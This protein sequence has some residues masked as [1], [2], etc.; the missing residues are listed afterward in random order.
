MSAETV[1]RSNRK[2]V[3]QFSV[4]ADNKVGRL[5]EFLKLLGKYDIHVMALCLVD[6]TDCTIM[7]FV[8]DYPEIAEQLL[9]EEGLAYNVVDV[10][11]VEINSEADI[12]SVTYALT[13]AEINIHYMYA[14]LSR[15]QGKSGLIISLEDNELATS[16]LNAARVTV[17]D[18][19]DIAR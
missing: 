5:N 18:Q 12:P 13:C 9:K 4:F 2:P 14:T 17:I 10:I 1:K 3:K 16:V 8:F 11:A 6:T 15:P 19:N 7:R